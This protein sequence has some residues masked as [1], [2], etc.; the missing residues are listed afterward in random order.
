ETELA[1]AHA[2]FAKA[3][4]WIY[5]ATATVGILLLVI[6]LAADRDH[7]KE[8]ARARLSLETELRAQY[9]SRHLHLLAEELTRLGLR[10]EVNLLH[11]NMEPER[12]LLR[13]S[14]EKSTFFN[15][16][17]AILDPAGGVLWSEPQTFLASGVPS[18]L[19]ALLPSLARTGVQVV[20]G[21]EHRPNSAILY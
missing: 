9:L 20:P 13:L 19:R 17:V 15:V 5:V 8:E 12:S 1:L 16:G 10:S 6:T 21:Q 18:S 11:E 7:Q 2:R 3:A 14:H 4:M